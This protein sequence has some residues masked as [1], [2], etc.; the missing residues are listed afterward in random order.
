MTLFKASQSSRNEFGY[1]LNKRDLVG[2][3]VEIGTHRGEFANVLLNNWHGKML[4]C[5]DPWTTYREAKHLPERGINRADDYSACVSRLKNHPGRYKLIRSTSEAA[6]DGFADGS[7]DF[8]YIDG[9]HSYES[10]L[11]D[12][13]SWWRKLRAGGILAGHDFV[14]PGEPLASHWGINVQRAVR[15]FLETLPDKQETAVQLVC[16]ENGLPWSF[17]LERK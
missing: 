3:A 8:V 7:L 2:S 4:Y 1:L 9:D 5:V 14:S 11:F 15:E 17:Y 10:V 13:G 12:L 16:E 6:L